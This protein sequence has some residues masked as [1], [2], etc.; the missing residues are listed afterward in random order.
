MVT[1]KKDYNIKFINAM[2]SKDIY[3]MEQDLFVT[4]FI[5]RN[6]KIKLTLKK[7]T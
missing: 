1:V 6:A 7:K 3:I 4:I 5:K 2:I